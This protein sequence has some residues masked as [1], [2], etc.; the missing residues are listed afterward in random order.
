MAR[1][2]ARK[3]PANVASR[4]P[5]EIGKLEPKYRIK[6]DNGIDLSSDGGRF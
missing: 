3:N 2:H 1:P 5:W 6:I 4:F